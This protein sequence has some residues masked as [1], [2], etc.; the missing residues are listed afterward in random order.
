[1]TDEA[2]KEGKFDDSVVVKIMGFDKWPRDVSLAFDRALR[3]ASLKYIKDDNI[4]YASAVA[5]FR[6]IETEYLKHFEENSES[7][8]QVRRIIAE[9][10]FMAAWDKDEPFETCQ[11]RWNDVVQLGFY[12][13][14]RED[15][16]TG[17]F[18]AICLDFGQID[19]GLS[20]VDPFIAKLERLRA[21]PNLTAQAIKYYNTEIESFRKLRARLEAERA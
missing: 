6:A 7:A 14:E 9:K 1:M 16:E 12:C 11:Q 18:A 21:E 13:I 4:T 19:L 17:L 20:V 2:N 10:I 15:L 5:D 8:L 3:V